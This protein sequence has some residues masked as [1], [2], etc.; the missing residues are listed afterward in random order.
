MI[1]GENIADHKMS[2]HGQ[3]DN[4]KDKISEIAV[5]ERKLDDLRL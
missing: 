1:G 4:A 3:V 5:N 2:N